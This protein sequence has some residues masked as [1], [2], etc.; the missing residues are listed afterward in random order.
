MI[1]YWVRCWFVFMATMVL[2]LHEEVWVFFKSEV[3]VSKKNSSIFFTTYTVKT[4]S[5]LWFWS[6]TYSQVPILWKSHADNQHGFAQCRGTLRSATLGI[7]LGWATLKS[8]SLHFILG[9]KEVVLSLACHLLWTSC[10][11]RSFP[12]ETFMRTMLL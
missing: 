3:G 8:L 1:A 6:C 12:Q 2:S 11:F 10:K 9:L 7:P 4:C 5:S